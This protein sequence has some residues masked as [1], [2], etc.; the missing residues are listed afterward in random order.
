[1]NDKMKDP[2]TGAILGAAIEV[3]RTLGPGF[4]E[5]VYQEAL[6][7]EFGA[8]D[9][10][11]RRE[12]DLPIMYKG[13]RLACCYRADFICF[14]SVI[15]ELKALAAIGN[16]EIAQVLNY[17]KA[18]NHQRALL[19]NF[20]E[21]LLEFKRLVFSAHLRPSA[22]SADDFRMDSHG[23]QMNAEKEEIVL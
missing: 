23:K 4:L 22:S 9:V 11:F 16:L 10:P 5:P 15:V 20:G 7:I 6:A 18:T 17:L 2:Q 21:T 1:M 19:L 13:R 3:H 12:V 14:D 8:R